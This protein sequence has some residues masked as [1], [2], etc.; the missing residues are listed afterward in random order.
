MATACG[1]SDRSRISYRR[2]HSQ[3]RIFMDFQRL[4][5]LILIIILLR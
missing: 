2:S 4:A 1:M 3:I 5:G